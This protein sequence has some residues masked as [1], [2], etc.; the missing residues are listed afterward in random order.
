VFVTPLD[1]EG[2]HAPSTPGGTDAE[3]TQL[4]EVVAAVVAAHGSDPAPFRPWL[5]PLPAVLPLSRV[6]SDG[7]STH[8]AVGVV[9]EPSEQRQSLYRIDLDAVG[10]ILVYGTSG[11]GK[12][13]FLRTLV[14][15]LASSAGPDELHIY[16]LDFSSHG[17]RVLEA[18][19]H[20]GS[21]VTGDE[22]ARVRRLLTMIRT[23]IT[24]RRELLADAGVTNLASYLRVSPVSVPRIVVLL[25]GYAGFTSTF[26]KIDLGELVDL[27]PRLIAD[28]RQ[29][30]IHFVLSAERRGVVPGSIAGLVG[31]RIVLPMADDD[32]YAA[33]GADAR[34][35]RGTKLPPGRAFVS[36]GLQM[37]VAIASDDGSGSDELATIAR[38]AKEIDDR[39]SGTGAPAVRLLPESVDKA[40]IPHAAGPLLASI[41]LD[42]DLAPVVA[43]LGDA[44]FVIAGPYRS[45]RSTALAGIA[46]G[47]ARSTDEVRLHLLAP[48]RS[49]LTTLDRWTDVAEGVSA[50]E[51]AV[52][53][54]VDELTA[55]GLEGPPVIVVVDDLDELFDGTAAHGLERIA[56]AGRDGPVR[57]LAAVENHALHRAF[58]GVASELRKDK[59]GLLLDPDVDIDGDLLGVRLPR[60]KTQPFPP[61]RGYLVQRGAY[62]LVQVAV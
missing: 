59:N 56:R 2:P 53:A 62:R 29:L 45:G 7:T 46:F 15:T 11:A 9:D 13:T 38:T 5:P 14:V 1:L 41:G 26:E 50:C 42:E 39:S 27:L 17:L 35:I 32:E 33:A 4:Q 47:L 57:I 60:R 28:G 31:T 21:V 55:P 52:A 24:G 37:Q 6:A 25:D 51:T 18:L 23:E 16:G 12:T 22:E 30:G 61:G 3:R 10:S 20:V 34:A 43:D 36:G 49:P 8:P 58:G 54:L 19:P 48:R 44:H 40:S